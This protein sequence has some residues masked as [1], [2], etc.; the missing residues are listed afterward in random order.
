MKDPLTDLFNRRYLA[1]II[2]REIARAERDKSFIG[3]MMIDADRFK[4][5]NDRFGH[6][7]GDKVLKEISK[8]LQ[9][10]AR[11]M[12]IVTRYGGNEFLVLLPQI[13]GGLDSVVKRFH[14]AIE[15]WNHNFSDIDFPI[16]LSIG[17]SVWD[18]NNPEDVE[19]VIKKADSSMY[20]VKDERG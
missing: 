4:E 20:E 13:D 12:D 10:E 8:V 9:E 2:P 7:V 14:K 19:D 3:F 18:P 5:V 17:T 6:L 1:T 16:T 11:E 15:K